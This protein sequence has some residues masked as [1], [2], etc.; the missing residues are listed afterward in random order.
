M[1]FGRR[2]LA[3]ILCFATPACATLVA[4][5]EPALNQAAPDFRATTV[6]GQA[7]SLADFKGQVLVLDFWAGGCTPCTKQLPLLDS[8]YRLQKKFGLQVLA[9][10][11]GAS[12]PMRQLKRVA[13]ALAVPLVTSFKGEYGAIQ[14]VP[15]NYVIDRAGVLRYAKA[16]V[17]TLDD[18]NAL[19]I[20]L[21]LEHQPPELEIHGPGDE[22]TMNGS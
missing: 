9:V 3:F 22:R 8:Y 15:I 16:A 4:A 19:L 6:D 21:L 7:V 11:R 17:L 1:T 18:M 12:V 13:A 10:S 14:P 5:K 2:Y 20:P